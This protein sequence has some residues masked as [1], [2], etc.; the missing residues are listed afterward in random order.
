[1]TEDRCKDVLKATTMVLLDLLPPEKRAA[2]FEEVAMRIRKILLRQEAAE[3][4]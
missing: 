3:T 4:E 2:A 1:M